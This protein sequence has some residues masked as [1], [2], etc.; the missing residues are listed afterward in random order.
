V[1]L[2]P[3]AQNSFD[4]ALAVQNRHD[5]EG[6]GLWAVNNLVGTHG[7]ER[8]GLYGEVFATVALARAGGQAIRGLEE[9]VADPFGVVGASYS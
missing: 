4:V 9:L 8:N 3:R 5:F 6:R 2:L 1:S 7:P